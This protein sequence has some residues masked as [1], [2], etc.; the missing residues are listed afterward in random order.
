[1]DRTDGKKNK[2]IAMAKIGSMGN[3]ALAYPALCNGES[4]LLLANAGLIMCRKSECDDANSPS[5]STS[6][7][8]RIDKRGLSVF[9]PVVPGTILGRELLEAMAMGC[10]LRAIGARR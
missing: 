4:L 1:M 9:A 10:E 7:A 6:S 8:C 3:I 5:L 2:T